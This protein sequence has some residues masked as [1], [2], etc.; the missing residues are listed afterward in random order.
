MRKATVVLLLSLLGAGC[1]RGGWHYVDERLPE[2]ATTEV[3]V[4]TEPAGADVSVN[5]EFLGRS[6]LIVP[7]RY[8]FVTRVFERRRM[9]PWPHVEEREVPVY[10]STF[11]FSAVTTGFMPAEETLRPAGE[12]KLSLRLVLTPRPPR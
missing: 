7:V 9:L 2:R 3:L 8:P 1:V 6:P 11:T 4:Q 10:S 12:E 5:G